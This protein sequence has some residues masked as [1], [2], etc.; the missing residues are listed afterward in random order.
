M[1]DTVYF[2]LPIGVADDKVGR[3]PHIGHMTVIRS[4]DGRRVFIKVFPRKP[5]LLQQQLPVLITP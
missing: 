3:T 5:Y 4:N 1:R 2:T